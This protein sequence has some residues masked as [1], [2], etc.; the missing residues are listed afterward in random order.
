MSNFEKQ[1]KQIVAG[2]EMDDRPNA[3]HKDALRKQML[4]ARK[5]TVST[6]P[7]IQPVLSRIMKS[8]MTK[9]AAAAAIIAC[10]SI[11]F[12][13]TGPA[14]ITLADVQTSIASKTWICIKYNNKSEQWTNLK[15]KK[16]FKTYK[17]KN[18][19]YAGVRD[20]VEGLWTYYHSNWGQQIHEK[21][22][23]THPYPLTAWDYAVS[24]W[25]DIGR[26]VPDKIERFDDKIDGRPV[27]R[28]DMYN[29][30][31]C[32]LRL[33]FQQVWADPQTRLPVRI[34]KYLEPG[35]FCEGNFIFPDDGPESI[36]DFGVPRDLEIVRNWGIIEPEAAKIINHAKQA[37]H[38]LPQEMRIIETNCQ[39]NTFTICYR[40]GNKFRKEYYVPDDYTSVSESLHPP[41]DPLQI[42]RWAEDH[43][44]NLLELIIFD[45]RYEYSYSSHPEIAAPYKVIMKVEQRNSDWIDVL[46]P[47]RDQWPYINFVGPMNVLHHEPTIPKGCVL[48]R[49]QGAD[50]KV[51]FYI[52]PERD[53]ICVKQI[54]WHK[55]EDTNE[56]KENAVFWQK[57]K[58]LFRLPSEQWYAQTS[59]D[60]QGEKVYFD[61]KL[62]SDVEKR[63]LMELHQSMG[64]FDGEQ[65]LKKAMA[66]DAKITFWAR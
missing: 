39:H 64:F 41:E 7:R 47:I 56:W 49:H 59:I 65:L 29:L 27:V 5:E 66:Q 46:M 40:I 60:V 24:G 1:F 12:L 54:Q 43:Q 37:W 18:N 26:A 34:R 13:T 63:R 20:H 4:A 42:R 38:D 36:Y 8:N 35:K 30:G 17:D 25:D 15:T 48:L 16:S 2:L 55:N 28:F 19:F 57:R 44:L 51:D 6:A 52:D 14:G 61:V 23:E 22:F 53:Y 3:E 11:W 32:G 9:S 10:I 50:L 62:L 45:G 21:P 33:L 31:P 58:D